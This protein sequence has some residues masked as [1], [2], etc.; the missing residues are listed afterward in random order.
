M[1][2]LPTF[3]FTT[4]CTFA[5]LAGCG[6]K[7]ER[8][9]GAFPRSAVRPGRQRPGHQAR[10]MPQGCCPEEFWCRQGKNF[11]L[12]VIFCSVQIL[13]P[14]LWVAPVITNLITERPNILLRLQYLGTWYDIQRLPHSFQKGECSTATYSL[15]SPGV[16]GVLNRELLWV[17]R[18]KKGWRF[19]L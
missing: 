6:D 14:D 1:F 2:L 15:K 9:P 3:I 17:L 12:A 19:T 16:V 10:K 5:S 4:R 18:P 11:I 7:D 13:T 8:H